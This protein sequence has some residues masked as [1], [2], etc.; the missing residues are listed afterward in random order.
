MSD[1]RD[2]REALDDLGAR[3]RAA[4]GGKPGAANGLDGPGEPD[5]GPGR[6][7]GLGLG[8]RIGVE[9]VATLAVGGGIGYM[10]DAWAGTAPL[11]MVV[12]LFLGGAAGVSNVYRVVK[13]LDE[14]VGLG[15]AI[16]AKKRHDAEQGQ[17]EQGQAEHGQAEH[18][19]AEHGRGEHGRNGS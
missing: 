8:M 14:G 18:G 6:G 19:Q 15:R 10:I 5:A 9:L 3:I 12:F 1:D 4:G 17:A 2:Q 7:A 13:G 11:F 16:E